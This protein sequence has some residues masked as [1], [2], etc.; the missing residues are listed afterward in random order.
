MPSCYATLTSLDLA[1]IAMPTQIGQPT[2]GREENLGEDLRASQER[3]HHS[4][5]C[6][7]LDAGEE[8]RIHQIADRNRRNE[9]RQRRAQ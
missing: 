1:E 8:E 2:N 7:E 6:K 4:R 9:G 5:V 3:R